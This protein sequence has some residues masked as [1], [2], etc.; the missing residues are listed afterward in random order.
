M[1]KAKTL[2]ENSAKN[3]ASRMVPKLEGDVRF[4]R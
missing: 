1:E 4:A 3:P 2:F